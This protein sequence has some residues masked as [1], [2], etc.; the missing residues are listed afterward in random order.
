MTLPRSEEREELADLV[1]R[2]LA[3]VLADL[4][5]LRVADPRRPLRTVPLGEALP[6]A[7]RRRREPPREAVAHFLG[8]RRLARGV[9]GES[10]RGHVAAAP[11]VE[12]RRHRLHHG[13]LLVD[14]VVDRDDDV[15]AE[16]IGL[17]EAVLGE[18]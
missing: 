14:D 17:L 16:R 3:A 12:L 9:R 2:G 15:A 7:V 1:L 18:E 8:A 10:A 11:L 4:E 6:E 5:G 13:E